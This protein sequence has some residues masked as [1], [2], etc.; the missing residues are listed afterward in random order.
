VPRPKLSEEWVAH[1]QRPANGV[2]LQ[3]VGGSGVRASTLSLWTGDA[4]VLM[5]ED[6][7]VPRSLGASR[8]SNGAEGLYRLWLVGITLT[9]RET[10][11]RGLKGPG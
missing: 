3:G 8:E 10:I 7:D 11:R 4:A 2:A 5:M 9:Y 6:P 1:L